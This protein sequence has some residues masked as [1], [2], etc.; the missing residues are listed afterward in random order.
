MLTSQ[1]VKCSSS[2]LKAL[3]VQLSCGYHCISLTLVIIILSLVIIVQS[4]GYSHIYV[5][6]MCAENR[7]TGE[8]LESKIFEK[9]NH[10]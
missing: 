2:L 3:H 10:C 1:K 5:R 4:E 6:Q 7:S 8:N 9:P